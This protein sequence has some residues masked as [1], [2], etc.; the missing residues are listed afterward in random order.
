MIAAGADCDGQTKPLPSLPIQ[1]DMQVPDAI[2]G[3][4]MFQC[5]LDDA[6]DDAP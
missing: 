1:G 5:L 3:D 6:E 4:Q 2:A